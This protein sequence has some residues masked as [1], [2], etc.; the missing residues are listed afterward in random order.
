MAKWRGPVPVADRFSCNGVPQAGSVLGPVL[1]F[2]GIHLRPRSW[3]NKTT[4]T[5]KFA[6]DTINYLGQLRTKLIT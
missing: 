3:Y 6:D 5:L 2:L 1:F 4:R